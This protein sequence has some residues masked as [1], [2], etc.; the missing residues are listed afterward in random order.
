MRKVLYILGQLDDTD[1]DWLA[2][3]GTRQ[4]LR[5]GGVLIRQGE[6]TP[7]LYI[8][9]DGSLDVT[10]DGVGSVA[11]LLSGEIIGEMGFVD[12][13]P[14][15]ATVSAVSEALLLAIPKEDLEEKIDAEPLFGFRFYKALALFL[16][17]RLRNT[18]RTRSANGGR[19]SASGQE[20]EADELD[21]KLLDTVA[22]AG[23]RFDRLV[24]AVTAG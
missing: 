15:S 23:D 19:S 14:P 6:P 18:Q 1:I 21:E 4:V 22:I 12:S 20:V 10:V 3:Y 8:V 7:N 11:R 13:S 2:R 5:P 24:R 17:D 9:I 16:A